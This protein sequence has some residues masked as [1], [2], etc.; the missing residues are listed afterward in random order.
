MSSW[1]VGDAPT[2]WVEWRN[3]GGDLTGTITLLTLRRPDGTTTTPTVTNPS[4]GRYEA[5]ITV[6][7]PGTWS[8][9]WVTTDV[10]EAAEEGRLYVRRSAVLA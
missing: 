10:L 1:D 7:Q 3:P 9:R 2:L 8:Y 5:V 4:T 6:D